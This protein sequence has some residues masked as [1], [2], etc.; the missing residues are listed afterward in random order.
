MSYIDTRSEKL[1]ELHSI[2]SKDISD[3]IVS[4]SDIRLLNRISDVSKN[5]G[6]E[7]SLFNVFPF[8]Y[9]RLDHSFGVACILENFKQS[10]LN[11]TRGLL[12]EAHKP[13]FSFSVDYLIDYFKF[14]DYEKK[15]L[16]DVLLNSKT[17]LD[18]ALSNEVA[19][20]DLVDYKSYKLGFATFP[21]LS[22]ETLEFVLSNSFF[23]NLCESR[24]IEELYNNISI[25]KNEDNE[26]EFC[27]SDVS[28]ATKFF[29]IS[30]EIGRKRRSYEAKIT[31]QLIADVLML[32][33]RREEISIDDL[34]KYSDE[35]LVNLGK[36][37]T[38]KRIQEGWQ[39]IENLCKVYT[40]F[41]PT[42]DRLKYCVK[43]QD[44]SIYIDPLIKT[45]MGNF[46]LS[47]ISESVEREIKTYLET[48]TDMYMYI[49][50]EL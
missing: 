36:S 38:D 14:K 22:A 30:L 40:K 9:S 37:S 31:E 35:E 20:N 45:K 10:T 8:K 13:S 33:I 17:F 50:Y 6:I 24:E 16:F 48:D 15:T 2:Y 41:N 1:R 49:D 25:C 7:R 28:L 29:K 11:I 26:D 3:Y 5:R 46:R 47:S 34:Y 12:H 32:M 44:R 21:K 19:I 27:F 43:V 39:Q 42:N 23:T 4:L 18:N